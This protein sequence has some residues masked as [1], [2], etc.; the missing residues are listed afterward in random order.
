MSEI[1]VIAIFAIEIHSFTPNHVGDY[2]YD[3]PPLNLY[4]SFTVDSISFCEMSYYY[5]LVWPG[6]SNG[7]SWT[8]NCGNLGQ[9]FSV[10]GQI[11]LKCDLNQGFSIN[12]E[13][14]L[15]ENSSIIHLILLPN[16]NF[17]SYSI[18][19]IRIDISNL[20]GVTFEDIYSNIVYNQ[21]L[22]TDFAY[23]SIRLPANTFMAEMIS[24]IG[25]YFLQNEGT[26]TYTLLDF[27][28]FVPSNTC[29]CDFQLN[30][31]FPL[32]DDVYE[33]CRNR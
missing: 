4:G 23:L 20:T 31:V 27:N 14:S 19:D 26:L 32:Q 11:S 12:S 24:R 1:L 8:Q 15:V 29:Y 30:S 16:L 2:F 13:C 7:E 3:F 6:L 21:F 10:E 9:S 22:Q 5:G 33:I 17:T 25:T 28:A 18:Y